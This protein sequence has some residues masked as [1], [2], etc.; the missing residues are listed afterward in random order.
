[1]KQT[2]IVVKIY[3]DVYHVSWGRGR[4]DEG[5]GKAEEKVTQFSVGYE[6]KAEATNTR[7]RAH[8]HGL[9]PG[10]RV[11]IWQQ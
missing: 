6:A 10:I 5:N 4:G 2:A 7:P 11:G 3:G 8:D 9:R 1:M